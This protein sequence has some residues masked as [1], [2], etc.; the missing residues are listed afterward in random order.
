MS[1]KYPSWGLC[2]RADTAQLEQLAKRLSCTWSVAAGNDGHAVLFAHSGEPSF[3]LAQR[4][5]AELGEPVVLLNFDDDLYVADEI[6]DDG[7]EHRLA[8]KPAGV[9]AA[10]GIRV[11]GNEPVAIFHAAVAVGANRAA[12]EAVSW[13]ADYEAREHGNGVLVTGDGT[14]GVSAGRW[15]RKLGCEVFFATWEPA[16]RTFLCLHDAPGVEE[17]LRWRPGFADGSVAGATEPAGALRAA[18][19]PAAP[20]GMD[21]GAP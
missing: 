20:L 19:I 18:G 6:R 4:L 17:M 12:L 8:E 1:T 13:E 10:H 21:E 3:R 9:L 15:A 11:P 14:L 5:A 7:S 16:T 2:A